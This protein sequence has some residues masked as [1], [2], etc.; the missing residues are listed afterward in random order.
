MIVE[1]FSPEG[2]LQFQTDTLI[3]AI[4]RLP[5]MDFVSTSVLEHASE[6]ENTGILHFVGDVRNGIFRQTAIAIGDGIRAAMRLNQVL[7]ETPDESD[8]LD[9]KRRYSHRIHRRTE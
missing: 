9:R 2:P 4:G 6:L 3:G 7:K 8:C 5:Q 1:C